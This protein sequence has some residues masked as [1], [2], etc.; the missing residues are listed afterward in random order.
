MTA[1]HH[2][3]TFH[4]TFPATDSHECIQKAPKLHVQNWVTYSFFFFLSDEIIHCMFT[5]Q[6]VFFTKLYGMNT[7]S[8][9]LNIALILFNNRY[10]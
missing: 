2:G 10:Y 9:S 7:T 6:L 1:V 5:M 4:V 3:V 8:R